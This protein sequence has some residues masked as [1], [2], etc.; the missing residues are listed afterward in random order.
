M[1]RWKMGKRSHRP[2]KCGW[3]SPMT[4]PPHAQ[5]P[6]RVGL[7]A[8]DP[9]SQ[10]HCGPWGTGSHRWPRK[11]HLP[12]TVVSPHCHNDPLPCSVQSSRHPILLPL[13]RMY[14]H[15]HLP[16]MKPKFREIMYFPRPYNWAAETGFK[17]WPFF[18]CNILQHFFLEENK[19]KKKLPTASHCSKKSLDWPFCS[20]KDPIPIS[21]SNFLSHLF[22][23]LFF[24][25]CQVIALAEFLKSPHLLCSCFHCP[26]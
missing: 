8:S 14:H 5:G 20:C 1:R 13:W 17:L 22:L 16:T 21:L 23:M 18:C 4:F 9:A 26:E 7:L 11:W 3:Q 2:V 19:Q 15:P 6:Q 10:K 24:I 12:S 25:S